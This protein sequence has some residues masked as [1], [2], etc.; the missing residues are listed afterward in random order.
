[1]L[2]QEVITYLRLPK[3]CNHKVEIL[4]HR[5]SDPTHYAGYEMLL[6]T[7]YTVPVVL[8]SQGPRETS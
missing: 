1:M 2:G 3:E 6:V 8:K 4:M 5:C 7:L